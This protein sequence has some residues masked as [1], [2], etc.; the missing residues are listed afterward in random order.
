MK[1]KFL[2]FIIILGLLQPCQLLLAQTKAEW[3]KQQFHL[4]GGKDADIVFRY[5]DVDNL[6]F[7]WPAG[8]DPFS[9]KTSFT[10][11]FPFKPSITDAAGTNRIMVTNGYS[12]SGNTDGYTSSTRRPDNKPVPYS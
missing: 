11:R 10:H 8:Y 9:G 12:N 4:A 3:K 5:G 1:K 6:N 2:H 7:G